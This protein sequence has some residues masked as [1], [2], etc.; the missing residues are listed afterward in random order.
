[1][2]RLTSGALKS[3]HTSALTPSKTKQKISSLPKSLEPFQKLTRQI[4]ALP[5]SK[6]PA[7]KIDAPLPP[8]PITPAKLM[9][10]SNNHTSRLNT[11][12]AYLPLNIWLNPD[13]YDAMP[14]S[15]INR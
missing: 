4:V 6:I 11:L 3:H 14:R 15:K 10:A 9:H 13:T 12:G 7:S 2:H 1:M 5:A 8:L